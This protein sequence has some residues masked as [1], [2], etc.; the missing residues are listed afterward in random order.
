MRS[1]TDGIETR[2]RVL[3]AACEV[4]AARGYR[5]AT[6][7]AICRKAGANSAA[8]NYHFN[9]KES[10]YV[11]VWRQS[12]DEAMRLYPLDGG[13]PATQGDLSLRRLRG[14]SRVRGLVGGCARARVPG[15]TAG[16]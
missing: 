10:L 3:Q 12:A 16:K 11:E 5:D 9:D 6:V 1:R 2:K 13:V 14:I 8:I 7:A 15:V 4:F